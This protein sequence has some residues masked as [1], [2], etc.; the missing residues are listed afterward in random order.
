MTL[1]FLPVAASTLASR[2]DTLFVAITAVTGA[3]AIGVLVVMSVFVVRYRRGHGTS[4]VRASPSSRLRA[5]RRLEVAWIGIPLLLF[6]AT[7]AWA[8]ALYFDRSSPPADAMEVSVVAKQWMWRVD[9][10]NGA[11]EINELHVPVGVPVKLVMTS[12]DVI[13]SFFVP[14]FRVKQDVLPGRYTVL[15]FTATRAGDYHLFC[16]E[17][18]GTDHS[19]MLGDVLVLDAAEYQRWLAGQEQRPSMAARGAQRFRALGCA[20][21]HGADAGVRA[22][23]LEGLYEHTVQLQGGKTVVADDDYLRD[24]ILLP[25]SQVV[26]GYDPIMPSYAGQV[27]ESEVMEI[28]AYIKSLAGSGATR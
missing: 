19:R 25:K 20:G 7:F 12:Q 6:I 16:A 5:Q 2:V 3:V 23:H 11:R 10:A 21:C 22:P 26:A 18:C 13:H 27:S 8:A 4:R 17:Y 24:S 1:P 9:H 15:W 28:I 14:E